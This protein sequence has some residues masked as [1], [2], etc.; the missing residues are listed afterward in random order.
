M[1]A[2]LKK[3]IE[4]ISKALT[5]LLLFILL[6]RTSVKI[7]SNTGIQNLRVKWRKKMP[8]NES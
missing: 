7:L 5:T 8:E 1:A 3:I 6:V 2:C 4:A